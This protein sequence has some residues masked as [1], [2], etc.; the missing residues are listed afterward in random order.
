MLR[1]LLTLTTNR[2]Y[3]LPVMVLM[4][5]SRCNCRCVMCDIWKSNHDKKEIST[6]VLQQHIQTFKR[7]GVKRVALSGGE[8]L[9]HANLW[10]FCDQLR[11]EER[12]VGKECRSRWS[13]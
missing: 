2:I 10:N 6:E 1:R 4:P 13:P 9:M 12:R 7:L 3:S 8:A 11:S 5:H